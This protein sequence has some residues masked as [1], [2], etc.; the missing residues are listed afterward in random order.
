MRQH[1]K[2]INRDHPRSGRDTDH[3]SDIEV[4]DVAC[5]FGAYLVFESSFSVT[6][7]LQAIPVAQLRVPAE[8]ADRYLR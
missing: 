5:L 8:W 1:A 2:T 6:Q 7:P 4:D 3:P